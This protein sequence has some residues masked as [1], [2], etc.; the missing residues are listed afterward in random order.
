[1]TTINV[2][3]LDNHKSTKPA[4]LIG[5]RWYYGRVN[6]SPVNTLFYLT[7]TK[8]TILRIESHYIDTTDINASTVIHDCLKVKKINITW[9]PE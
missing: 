8:E 4:S 7:A 5:A 3:R 2:Q 6:N 1:M 9:E